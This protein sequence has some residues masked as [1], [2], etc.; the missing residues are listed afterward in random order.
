MRRSRSGAISA[1]TGLPG[2]GKREAAAPDVDDGAEESAAL[3]VLELSEE[4][5]VRI[6]EMLPLPEKAL[7][8]QEA[9]RASR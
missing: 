3:V 7:A 5:I 1:V 8:I 4:Q 6:W 2:G 9:L